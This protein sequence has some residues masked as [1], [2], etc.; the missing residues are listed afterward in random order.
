MGIIGDFY[1]NTGNTSWSL[2]SKK[3]PRWNCS[4]RGGEASMK[5][6][7]ASFKEEFGDEPDDLK[8]FACKI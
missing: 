6:C 7:I 3:D 5:A 2:T 4:G 1:G 8:F